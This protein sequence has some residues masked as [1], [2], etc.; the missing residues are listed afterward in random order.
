M[1]TRP[2]PATLLRRAIRLAKRIETEG[3]PTDFR[4]RIRLVT[5]G[6]L[7]RNRRI[8]AAIERLGTDCAYESRMLLRPMV[9]TLINHAWIRLR[10]THS[11]ATRF[12]AYQQ[13]E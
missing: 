13:L 5:Y 8:A 3:R 1:A 6:F 4:R 10:D 11:R 9:E 12:V 2:N 7:I